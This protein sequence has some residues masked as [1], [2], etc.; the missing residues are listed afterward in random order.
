V[1]AFAFLLGPQPFPSTPTPTCR[2]GPSSVMN[3]A[4]ELLDGLLL[5]LNDRLDQ[6]TD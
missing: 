6:I 1:C 3:V 2:E 4:L 5:L